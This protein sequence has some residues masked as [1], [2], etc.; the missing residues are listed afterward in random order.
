MKV[1]SWTPNEIQRIS[2]V[3]RAYSYALLL[4]SAAEQKTAQEKVDRERKKQTQKG[5]DRGR[6][7]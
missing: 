5:K 2:L 7:V 1:H 4:D 3:D 6:R